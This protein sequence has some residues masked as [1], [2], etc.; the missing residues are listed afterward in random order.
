[1]TS[2]RRTQRRTPRAVL[3]GVVAGIGLVLANGLG[4]G[5]TEEPK[6]PEAVDSNHPHKEPT[7][8]HPADSGIDPAD[9]ADPVD[10]AVTPDAAAD[11][12]DASAPA[13]AGADASEAASATP[14]ASGPSGPA[15]C[16]LSACA[17]GAPCPD[18]I[19]DQ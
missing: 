12:E 9:A 1:M 8:T 5:S 2:R 15:V 19:I 3:G 7:S 10:V 11:A 6:P 17:P 14:E 13:D 16:G 18:L 4:C